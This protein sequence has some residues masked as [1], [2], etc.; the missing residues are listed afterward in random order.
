MREREIARVRG[1]TRPEPQ[2]TVVNSGLPFPSFLPRPLARRRKTFFVWCTAAASSCEGRDGVNG[3]TLAGYLA[4]SRVGEKATWPNNNNKQ[5]SLPR[6]L[7][8]LKKGQEK[9]ARV[10]YWYSASSLQ[11]VGG[12]SC[13]AL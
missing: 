9:E 5:H 1:L 2:T 11:A 3:G 12:I 6:A 13:D 8:E 4:P 7:R 10:C